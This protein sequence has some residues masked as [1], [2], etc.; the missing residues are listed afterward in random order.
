MPFAYLDDATLREVQLAAID[1]G[2][3]TDGHLT[4][5]TAGISPR[6]VASY[7]RGD[8]ALDRLLTLTTKMNHTRVLVSGEVPLAKWLS[9]AILRA[10]GA[11]EELVFRKALE[12][13]SLDGEA[14]GGTP[15]RAPDVASLPTADDGLEVQISTDEALGVAFLHG[16]TMAARSV[17]KLLVHRHFG[18]TP[19]T[20]AG[21]QPD[22]VNGTGWVLAPRLLITS[23]HVVNAR[24]SLEFPAG[25]V[26]F[27]LQGAATQVLFDYYETD[28]PVQ[29]TRS[30][31]C[32]ASDQD[33][34]YA[35]LRLPPDAPDRQ[36]L[37]LRRC[38][39]M[40]PTDHVLRE[41]VNVLQ[42][43][44][45]DSMRLAF[46]NNFV[47]T[48]NECRL[49]YLTDT[50]GGSS[51]SP[52]FDDLW[53]VVALH[54]AWT[55][56]DPPLTVRSH[57]WSRTIKQENYGSP[58]RRILDH[59]AVNYPCLLDEITAGQAALRNG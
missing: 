21:D 54:R 11:P 42:H 52:V 55:T 3:A 9:N 5:L 2:F 36:P 44:N 23:F 51:G 35:L 57:V 30:A 43:P 13:I 48:G 31:G 25:D 12:R 49:S 18:G 22:L 37:R 27:E 59:L 39:V 47:V 17:A 40:K 8:I 38:S 56:L 20:L 7:S 32:V 45:G 50:A 34:D 10:G 14:A 29:A 24:L 28:S 41:R 33:L 19:S 26:D 1:L 46:R 58:I 4:V 53:H 6:F 16:G 15:V